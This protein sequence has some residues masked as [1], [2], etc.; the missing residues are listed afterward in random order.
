M[1]KGLSQA[2]TDIKSQKVCWY[3]VVT[4][5]IDGSIMLWKDVDVPLDGL[6]EWF[7]V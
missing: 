6:C 3:I 4:K 7:C 5:F 1:G 2:C